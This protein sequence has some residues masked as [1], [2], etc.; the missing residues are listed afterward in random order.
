MPGCGYATSLILRAGHFGV[1]AV[2]G[3]GRLEDQHLLPVVHVG[4]DEDLDGLVGAV[5]EDELLGLDV[6]IGR[7]GLLGLAV[8]GV[9]GEASAVT[10][11]GW[12]R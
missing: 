7:D 9:D 11:C 5:G 8:F 6:E 10:T 2:H 12:R 3:V 4:V 1:E